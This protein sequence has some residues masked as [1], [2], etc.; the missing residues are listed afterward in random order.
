M[1]RRAGIWW[2]EREHCWI[3]TAVGEFSETTGRRKPVRNRD[4]GPPKGRDGAANQAAAELWLA[5]RIKAD[6]ARERRATGLTLDDLANLY[7]KAMRDRLRPR[8]WEGYQQRLDRFLDHP[9]GGIKLGDHRLDD[10]RPSH[11][12]RFIRAMEKDDY[13][14]GYVNSIVLT[15]QAMLNWAAKPGTGTPDRGIID[16]NPFVGVERPKN[17]A[18]P[19]R[20]AGPEARRAFLRFAYGRVRRQPAGSMRRRFDW[21]TVRLVR[22]CEATGCRPSEAARL[23]WSMI[24]WDVPRIV[25]EGKSTGK[26]GRQRSLPVPTPA[27]RLLRRIDRLAGHHPR[28]VFTHPRRDGGGRRDLAGAPWNPR[29]LAQKFRIWRTEAIAAGQPIAADGATALTLYALR[30]D[31]GADILRDTGSHARSAEVLGHSPE[32]NARHYASFAEGHATEL[33][34]RIAEARRR[35][36]GKA[37]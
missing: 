20:Y 2:S 34:E 8:T 13:K 30:R 32:I 36:N 10:L 3:T 35:A 11:L 16:A 23:E 37:D 33:A 25:M 21:L 7:R 26:T 5:E 19:K 24:D 28:Y 1:G 31:M 18:P 17:P 29:A 15:V 14:P 6:A 27:L 22:F 12:A 9:D 4:I